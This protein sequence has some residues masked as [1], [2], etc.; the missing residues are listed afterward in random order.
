MQLVKTLIRNAS[1]DK[2]PRNIIVASYDGI[3]EH[4][5]ATHTPHNYYVLEGSGLVLQA[6]IQIKCISQD[7]NTWPIDLDIDLIICN[8]IVRQIA[9]CTQISN[10][11]QIP[12]LIIH[13]SIAPPFVKKEDMM[14]LFNEYKNTT[15]VVVNDIINKSW[16]GKFPT[17]PY[18]TDI[19]KQSY[20][21]SEEVLIIGSFEPQHAQIIQEIIKHTNKKI[22][23]MGNNPNLSKLET[24]ETC[25]NA[26]KN[27]K[28]FLNLWNDTE[29]NEFMLFAMQAGCTVISNPSILNESIIKHRTN[30]YIAKSID[31]IINFINMPINATLVKAAQD[32]I[33]FVDEWS[34]LIDK[35]CHLTYRK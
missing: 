12:L 18:I 5:L 21:K 8:D 19:D 28:I 20:V 6:D 7:I 2:T 26:I 22:T 25:I 3:F 1:K 17:M 11:M 13:H 10:A 24:F 32:T 9:I 27:H 14:I 30:G 29:I 33:P 35:L 16:Y 31:E 4:M 15:R 23:V 34:P